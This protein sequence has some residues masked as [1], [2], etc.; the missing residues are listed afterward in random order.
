[1]HRRALRV[2]PVRSHATFDWAREREE[3]R[4]AMSAFLAAAG[5]RVSEQLWW[6]RRMGHVNAC[7]S[8]FLSR[9]SS[10]TEPP[11]CRKGRCKRD[12][13]LPASQSTSAQRRLHVLSESLVVGSQCCWRRVVLVN[14]VMRRAGSWLPACL[15]RD[16]FESAWWQAS[17]LAGGGEA[18]AVRHGFAEMSISKP[19]RAGAGLVRGSDKACW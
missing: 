9:T 7:P 13:P 12:R 17:G 10:N 3:G 5:P 6:D 8:E 18:G 1:M 11:A 16:D 14:P 15:Q 2:H 4:A 19:R